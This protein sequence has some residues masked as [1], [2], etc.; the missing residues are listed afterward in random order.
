MLTTKVALGLVF[1]GLVAGCATNGA[2]GDDV[3][4]DDDG[5]VPFTSGVS[6]LAGTQEAGYVDGSRRDARFNNPVNVIYRDGKLFVADFDNSKLRMIDVETHITTTVINQQSFQ[7]PFGL[8]FAPDGTLYVSTDKNPQGG[9]DLMSGTIWRVDI[10]KKTATAIAADIGRPRGIAVLPDGRIVAVDR[11]HHVVEV[12]DPA[13]GAVEIIAGTWDS[14]G[15]VD[16]PGATARFASP[17]AVAVRSDGKL[18]VTDFDNNRLRVVGMDGTTATFAGATAG[19][20][21]G[22]M[23]NARFSRP[24]GL[25]MAA[26][27]DMYVTDLDNF[28]VRRIVGDAVQTIAGNGNGGHLDSDDPLA[29]ELFGL[30]GLSVVP[31]GSMLFVADGNRGD[32]GP[33]NRVRQIKLK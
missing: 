16:G 10:A 30:E 7:R 20:A 21:D 3:V 32:G 23:P 27:G 11:L 9:H 18:I 25:S 29:A 14:Q 12:V 26:N 24:Q 33:F 15:M 6:T 17:Y 4:G 22:A 31:D 13:S 2:G 8:A 19:F 28:R 1:A 5:D